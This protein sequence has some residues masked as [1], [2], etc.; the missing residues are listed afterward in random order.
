MTQAN[1]L[2]PG[3]EGPRRVADVV[4]QHADLVNTGQL[5]PKT[6]AELAAT[7][8]LAGRMFMCTDETGGAVPVFGDGTNWR[9]VTDRVIAS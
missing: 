9:R 5:Q 4:N 6:V 3:G 2:A 8:A 7:T 1:K